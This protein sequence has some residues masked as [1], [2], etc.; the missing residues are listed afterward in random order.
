MFLGGLTSFTDLDTVTAYL[1]LAHPA[2]FR[3]RPVLETVTPLPLH[4]IVGILIFIPGFMSCEVGLR[5]YSNTPK[6]DCNHHLQKR[7]AQAQTVAFLYLP[8]LGQ[9]LLDGWVAF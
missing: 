6:L 4:T 2:V 9:E 8:L 5:W 7:I 1:M 3:E